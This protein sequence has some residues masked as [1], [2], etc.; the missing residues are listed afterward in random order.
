MIVAMRI[1]LVGIGIAFAASAA[2]AQPKTGA[3]TPS[4]ADQ[5]FD[6]GRALMAKQD[7]ADACPKL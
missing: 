4:K 3:P 7:Y 1:A 6:E 5:L 2:R